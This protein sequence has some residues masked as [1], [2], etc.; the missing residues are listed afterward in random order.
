MGSRRD[1]RYAGSYPSA[2][3]DEYDYGYAQSDGRG[4]YL[5]SDAGVVA[6]TPVQEEQSRFS[7]LSLD[8]ENAAR[9]P[10]DPY[11]NP[12]RSTHAHRRHREGRGA[13]HQLHHHAQDSPSRMSLTHLHG[14]KGTSGKNPRRMDSGE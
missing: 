1:K 4:S 14:P 3:T 11:D 8:F 12:R 9:A 7:T 5:S 2:Q 10:H 6:A 13:R